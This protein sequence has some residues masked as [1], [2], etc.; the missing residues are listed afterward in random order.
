VAEDIP[1][2]RLDLVGVHEVIRD[3]GGNKPAGEYTFF[4]GKRNENH[5][6]GTGPSYISESYQKLRG[7][8]LLVI[9]CT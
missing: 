5:E 9:R 4:Y 6:L 1:N 3:R 7:S 8:S 2:F